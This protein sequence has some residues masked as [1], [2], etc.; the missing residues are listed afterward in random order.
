MEGIRGEVESSECRCII[1]RFGIGIGI[2]PCAIT[3][4]VGRSVRNEKGSSNG[5]AQVC[6]NDTLGGPTCTY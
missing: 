4:G 3:V 2:Y 5:T 6:R 1:V